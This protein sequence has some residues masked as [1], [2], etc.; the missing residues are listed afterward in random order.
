MTYLDSIVS[1]NFPV[2]A[3]ILTII[4][5]V[6]V[7]YNFKITKKVITATQKKYYN[8]GYIDGVNKMEKEFT[9]HIKELS[10]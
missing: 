7:L 8:L 3:L 4:L 10:K 9:K 5:L 1:E 6:L 2:I